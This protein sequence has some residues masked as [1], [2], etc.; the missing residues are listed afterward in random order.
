VIATAAIIPDPRND[1]N[2]PVSQVHLAIMRLHNRH[3]EA[4]MTFEE[5][6]RITRF[7]YQWVVVH[8]LMRKLCG[9]GRPNTTAD[10]IVDWT[11]LTD[12]A[13]SRRQGWPT[14]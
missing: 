7:E 2:V 8:D 5:A 12:P 9:G 6:Q 14:R 10:R 4:G 1:E 3:V 13:R 11:L